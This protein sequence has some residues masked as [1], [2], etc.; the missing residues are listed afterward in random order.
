LLS[1][2]GSIVIEV[3]NA[4]EKG[5]P[6]MSTLP[7]EALL[8][9]KKAGNLNL[10]QEIICHNPARLPS[11]AVWVNVQR[12]RLK[13]SFTHVWWMAPSETPK[14][15]NRRVLIP[16]GGAMKQLLKT[17]KYNSGP[18]PSGHKVSEKGFLTN[19]GG[20]ISANV[21]DIGP[22]NSRVPTSLLK[23]SGTAWD[24]KYRAYCAKHDLVPHPAR[25]QMQLAAFFIQLLTEPGDL[26]VDPFA[27]SNTTGAT[28]EGLG[29]RWI[30]VEA[31]SSYAEGSKGRFDNE[32][33]RVR[34]PPL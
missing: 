14:A 3:G 32:S 6:V 26:V 17:K 11:P 4:W 7:L 8:A 23:F 20:A 24:E 22:D 34:R 25:M 5:A 33:I 15:D 12:I 27:G 29:R 13:D 1:P 2:T 9:F 10:C 28:A 18:R 21:V 30:A 16:Y 19:H 31:D